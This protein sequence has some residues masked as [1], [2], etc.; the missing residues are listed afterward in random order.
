MFKNKNSKKPALFLKTMMLLL[1]IISAAGFQYIYAQG[2]TLTQTVSQNTSGDAL[3]QKYAR[4]L[5]VSEAEIL[6]FRTLYAF[7]DTWMGT[8]YLWGGCSKKG[9][10]CSCFVMT[11]FDDVYN[12]NIQRTSFTQF[13]DK[14]VALFKSRKQYSTGDLI[15]F[16]TNINR[17]T[18]NNRVTHVGF[19]LTNGYFVQSSSK[20]VNIASLNNGFWK[21]STVAAGRLKESFY[22]QAGM[23]VPGGEVQLNNQQFKAEEDSYFEPPLMNERYDAIIKK[24]ADLLSVAEEEIKIPEVLEYIENHNK[25]IF[26]VRNCK[27]GSNPSTCMVG[28]LYQKVFGVEVETSLFPLQ[29]SATV[30]TL[31]PGVDSLAI[32]DIIFLKTSPRLNYYNK[33]G[34]YLHNNQF[35]HIENGWM[36]VN[37]LN[38]PGIKQMRKFYGRFKN[39]VYDAAGKNLMQRRQYED[40]IAKERTTATS[41]APKTPAAETVVNPSAENNNTGTADNTNQPTAEPPPANPLQQAEKPFADFVQRLVIPYDF[42]NEKNYPDYVNTNAKML[43]V[44]QGFVKDSLVYAFA[45]KWNR[46]SY[47]KRGCNIDNG[48][49]ERCFVEKYYNEV[50]KRNI[51]FRTF[52]EV[53]QYHAIPLSKDDTFTEGD[54]L[55]FGEKNSNG[56]AEVE[57]AGIYLNGKYFL[58][59]SPRSKIV[60]IISVD[61]KYFS[62]KFINA[63]KPGLK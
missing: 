37:S 54:L 3:V 17:E 56:V 32:G 34:V 20:G 29:N 18:R 39:D 25:Q 11:L 52:E 16:K 15:F 44:H 41:I 26:S 24:Y 42:K 21:N 4:M 5:Q 60:E 10:D 19:Y 38:D 27:Q 13:Y 51:S 46:A 30:Y 14:D 53:Y 33:A 45:E 62:E 2:R 63:A 35:V 61:D 9:I 55:F 43:N 23:T 49:N 58:A 12:I 50:L 6:R 31:K 47:R 57:F 8:P 28:D 40:S 1:L 48:I 59:L 22:Q 36:V 7:I